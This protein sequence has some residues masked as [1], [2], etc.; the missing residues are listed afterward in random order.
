V[1]GST[2]QLAAEQ[3]LAEIEATMMKQQ[4]QRT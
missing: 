3:A 4:S 1:E 2:D